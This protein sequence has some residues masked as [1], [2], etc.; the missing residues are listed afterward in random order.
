MRENFDKRKL[1]DPQCM[2]KDKFTQKVFVCK[3][4]IVAPPHKWD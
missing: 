4:T 1:S 2:N 3:Y